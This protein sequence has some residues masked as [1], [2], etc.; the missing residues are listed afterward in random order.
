MGPILTTWRTF[1]LFKM[2]SRRPRVIPATFNSLV[3][4]IMWLSATSVS[5]QALLLHSEALKP[6]FTSSDADASSL[7]LETE[8]PFVLPQRGGNARL[9]PRGRLLTCGVETSVLVLHGVLSRHSTRQR[10]HVLWLGQR[11]RNRRRGRGGRQAVGVPVLAVLARIGV[12][13]GLLVVV[14]GG[15]GDGLRRRTRHVLGVIDVGALIH[16]DVAR[17]GAGGGAGGEK[18]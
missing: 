10:Q 12:L 17:G 14:H 1:S 6:T 9:H 7:N 2:P 15:R 11:V 4:L 13:C 5:H 3:P 8:T 16:G 18:R